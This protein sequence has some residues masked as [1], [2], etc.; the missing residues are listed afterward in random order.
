MKEENYF[1]EEKF[2][3]WSK[4]KLQIGT[5][6]KLED[7]KFKI[8]KCEYI[9]KEKCYAVLCLQLRK[10]AILTPTFNYYSG[11]DRVAEE[12]AIKAT[13]AGHEVTVF[14]LEAKIKP[15]PNE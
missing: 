4:E 7:M 2:E 13:N 8:L 10:I 12:K 11:P 14:A 3:I 6:G 5:T 15:N 9:K 1:E